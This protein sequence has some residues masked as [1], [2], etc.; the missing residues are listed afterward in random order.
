MTSEKRQGEA[1]FAK[2]R[3]TMV[4]RQLRARG[5]ADEQVLSAMRKVPRHRFISP[6]QWKEAYA[7]HPLPIGECQ[8]IS[9][10]Y[11]VALMSEALFLSGEETV[12]EIGTGS[13]YQTAILA[14]LANTVTTIERSTILSQAARVRLVQLGY[15]NIHFI[16]ADGTVG[17][18]AEAPFDRIIATGSLPGIPPGM[19]DQLSDNGILVLPVGDR[20]LQ[21]LMQ[22][23]KTGS[24]QTTKDLG[25]CRFVPL[26]G[27]GGWGS[28]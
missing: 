8:T 17:L 26:I 6:D 9:Q 20:T 25:A 13:G 23:K 22:I 14:E 15:R 18:P 1:W 11:I 12:L 4:H 2:Q 5:I 27:K 19:L 21:R 7:D 24:S 28:G 16:V 3:Q 10:P